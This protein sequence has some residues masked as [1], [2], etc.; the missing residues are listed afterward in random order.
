MNL[1]TN[2]ATGIA[3]KPARITRAPGISA[4][5]FATIA[6][7][8]KARSGIVLGVDKGYLVE[9][10]LLLLLRQR[11]IAS[12]A[13]LTSRLRAQPGGP[14]A[15]A[16]VDAMTTNESLFFRDGKPFEHL[17]HVVLPRLQ[18]PHTP[19]R[20]LRIWS[21]AA[22]SGQ[23]AYSIAM[24]VAEA[25]A[26]GRRV[27][28]LGTDISTEQILRARAGLYSQFEVQRGLPIQNLVRY[29]TKEGGG[30]RI[31]AALRQQVV[32]REWN[33]LDD[34]RSLGTF[35]VVFCRNVLIYF[36]PP[37]KR[38]VLDDIWRRLDP[39]GFLYLGGAETTLGVSDRF[40]ASP[41]ARQVYLPVPR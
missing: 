6:D 8:V 30:W 32:F 41:E 23:E 39:S 12:L 3:A 17:R 33:L 10:R 37:T 14:L 26:A 2:T 5:D 38:K 4:A 15:H 21:A 13:E 29:F 22:S 16:V 11:S 1:H 34:P 9:T 25:G 20:P 31:D 18:A 35:D 36:D 28:I 40:V 7:L 27:E 24:I 19:D